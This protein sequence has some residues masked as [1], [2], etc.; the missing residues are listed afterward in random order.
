[1]FDKTNF[2]GGLNL[3]FV[4]SSEF[5]SL[6]GLES[7]EERAPILARNVLRLLMMGWPD[8]WH[9]LISWETLKTIFFHRDPVLLKEF[10]YAFQQGFELLY[11]QLKDSQFTPEQQEQVQ[12]YLSNCLSIL[13]YSDLTPYESIKIPQYVDNKWILVEYFVTPIELTDRNEYPL[14]TLQ[15]NDR[16]FA[17]G[18]EPFDHDHAKS[19]LIFMGTTYPAGQGFISQINTDLKAFHTVG[20]SLY[21]SGRKRIL[22]WISRQ[23]GKIYTCGMSL[24]GALSLLLAI[25]QGDK[26]IR[27]DAQN[28]PGLYEYLSPSEFDHWSELPHQPKVVIQQ[29]AQDPVSI[30]GVWKKD[31]D[32]LKVTPP[33]NK[34]GPNAFC[35]H[36]LNYAGFAETVFTYCDPE[37]ENNKRRTRNLMLYA[38]GR[39]L[40][41][42]PLVWPY[43][44]LIR[45]IGLFSWKHKVPLSLAAAF[46]GGLVSV[47]TLGSLGLVSVA[48]MTSLLLMFS[49]AAVFGTFLFYR[50]HVNNARTD[51]NQTTHQK[52]D[53]AKI[54]DPQLPRNP[55]M[56]LYNNKIEFKISS[57]EYKTY[58]QVL[59]RLRDEKTIMHHKTKPSFLS[60]SDSWDTLS[61]LSEDGEMSQQKI[62]LRATKAKV[63]HIKQTLKL[64][65]HHQEGTIS[66][67]DR[68]LEDGLDRYEVGKRNSLDLDCLTLKPCS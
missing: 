12:L 45:P 9:Q 56:D 63:V 7:T 68:A 30:F 65:H 19:H 29:Q 3:K 67:L 14:M 11:Q 59:K 46:M 27:V 51:A 1:M 10:R 43:T 38:V 32:V 54:H 6:E 55:S 57:H 25:D 8:S 41:Y 28:P 36:V 33:Q 5:E 66:Q 2:K 26:L 15:D 21:R 60:K 16:V 23:N 47:I 18:L 37:I 61:N 39:V 34:K 13:P 64:I 49:V 17:Y 62:S 24:G 22:E 31:W 40:I 50:H 58:S 44:H 42:Y 48:W 52:L 35:D 53:L 4:D 20:E